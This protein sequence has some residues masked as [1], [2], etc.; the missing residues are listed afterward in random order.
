MQQDGAIPLR[1]RASLIH[2]MKNW[3]D[4]ASWQLFFDS[5][6]R[7]IYDVARKAGLSDSE[8]QDVVSATMLSVAR[9]MPNFEYDA[10][11]GSF[12]AW[13]LTTTRWRIVDR[14]RQRLAAEP[15]E[16]SESDSSVGLIQNMPDPDGVVPDEV[17]EKD[18][19]KNLLE[20]ALAHLRLRIDPQKYQLFEFYVR[21]EWP[22]D[23]VAQRFGVAVEQVYLAKH[24]ITIL[25]KSEIRRLQQRDSP[26]R[27]K[28]KRRTVR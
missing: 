18:W 25:L 14:V 22:A 11:R 24:R 7:L 19:K 21:K 8:A 17:W 13:L 12:K 1:T 26:T 3:R 5:Y 6:W 15:L 20:V 9:Q 16:G 27:V 2:R 10:K 23:K 28:R 4:D